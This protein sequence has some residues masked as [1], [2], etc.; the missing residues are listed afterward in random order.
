MTILVIKNFLSVEECNTL[1]AWAELGVQ[2]KWLDNGLNASDFT[3]T[4]TKRLTTRPYGDR[5]DYS[6]EVYAIQDKIT[7]FLKI[8]NLEK[9]VAGG[10]KNGI[11]VSYTTTGGD[12]HKHID[13]KE[14][15]LEVLRCNVVSKNSEAGGDLYIGNEKIDID[16]GDLHCYLP[17]DV[18]HYVT[19]VEGNTPRILW[20]FGY[21]ISKENFLNIKEGF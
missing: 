13:P 12:V 14:G 7:N 3:W 1:N 17:S 9:S 19:A 4:E 11:V 21:Q 2:N 5:F 18:E 10:G 6:P 20:M 8:E 15:E 16:A